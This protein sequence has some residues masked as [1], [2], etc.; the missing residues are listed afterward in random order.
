[1]LRYEEPLESKFFAALIL[2]P[3]ETCSSF[4]G[5]A[6]LYAITLDHLQGQPLSRGIVGNLCLEFWEMYAW[7]FVQALR[8]HMSLG[9]VP[10]KTDIESLQTTGQIGRAHV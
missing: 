10:G 4:N 5:C 7:Q 2:L 1:M 3:L 6:L 8:P 9:Q